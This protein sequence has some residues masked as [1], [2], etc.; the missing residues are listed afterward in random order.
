MSNLLTTASVLMCPHGGTVS[1][2]T[3]N[4]RAS[5][6]GAFLVRASDTF[7]IAGCTFSPGSSHPCMSVRW[8]V[9]NQRS[10]AMGDLTLSDSSLGICL[11]GDQTPQGS[12]IILNTQPRVSG[13]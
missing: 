7:T 6:A 11:A 3:S 10:R 1:V 9:A 12:I 2:A 13:T 5:A 8:L 4:N